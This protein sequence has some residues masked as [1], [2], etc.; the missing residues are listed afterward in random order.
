PAAYP[1]L[2]D[3]RQPLH[4]MLRRID[5][6]AGASN[7]PTAIDRLDPGH[8]PS[9]VFGDREITAHQFLQASQ[10]VFPVIDGVEM[11]EAQ[12]LG[13]LAG[14]DLVTLVALFHGGIL[15]RIA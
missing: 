10:T 8:H 11:I 6:L 7:A 1:W 15:S 13:Q 5:L 14:I 4:T 9:E 2:G 3:F 12:Q